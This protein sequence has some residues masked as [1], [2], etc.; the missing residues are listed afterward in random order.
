MAP[1]P[2]PPPRSTDITW[3]GLAALV[4]ATAAAAASSVTAV[5]ALPFHGVSSSALGS[6][7]MQ[8]LRRKPARNVLLNRRLQPR[9]G[10]GRRHRPTFLVT[11]PRGGHADFF[12]DGMYS[13]SD[14]NDVDA[15]ADGNSGNQNMNDAQQDEQQPY[16]YH[17]GQEP[18]DQLQQYHGYGHGYGYDDYQQQ[19]QLAQAQAEAA[20]ATYLSQVASISRMNGK[21]ASLALRLAVEINQKLRRGTEA[22]HAY[23]NSDDDSLRHLHMDLVDENEALE[24]P[25]PPPPPPPSQSQPQIHQQHQSTWQMQPFRQKMEESKHQNEHEWQPKVRRP[26]P[27][28]GGTYYS[29]PNQH[30]IFHA[31]SPRNGASTESLTGLRRWGMDLHHYIEQICR[32]ME[33]SGEDIPLMLARALIYL[34]RACS[35]DTER[36]Y[37]Y[38]GESSQPCPPLLPRTVHRLVLAAMVLSCRVGRGQGG[39]EYDGAYCE[40]STLFGVPSS[41]LATMEAIMRD[42]LG[43]EGLWIDF[44]KLV[45]YLAAWRQKFT[46]EGTNG[47]PSFSSDSGVTNMDIS[48]SNNDSAEASPPDNDV[49]DLD[50]NVDDL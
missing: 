12:D 27:E 19:Q 49:E 5:E 48:D 25:C 28:S 8:R 50:D 41:S 47:G 29:N 22:P 31:D 4:A 33:C 44:Y 34:D 13:D 17:Y 32:A 46:E 11:I 7:K 23:R 18:Q 38:N 40:I 2:P 21:T 15:D 16:G 1:L 9:R 45:H 37:G 36:H 20:Q 10:V 26:D 24:P 35:V 3:L 43:V 39:I 42:A 6:L 14:N 30:T